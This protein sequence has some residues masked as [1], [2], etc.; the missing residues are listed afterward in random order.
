MKRTVALFLTVL[1]SFNLCACDV[2]EGRKQTA[3]ETAIYT[4]CF[5]TVVRI[6]Y[7]GDVEQAEKMHAYLLELH[8]LF[9]IYESER[10]D[11]LAA[12]NKNAGYLPVMVDDRVWELLQFGKQCYT[13][14]DGAINMMM[15]SVLTLWKQALNNGILPTQKELSPASTHTNI[16]SLILDAESKTAFI[17]DSQ[18]SIDVGAFAKGYAGK[19]A[20]A[21]AKE[22]LPDV[23]LLDLGGNICTV[24]EK[25]DGSTFQI[26]IRD[27]RS[28]GVLTTVSVRAGMCVVSGGDYQRYCVIDGVRYHHIIDPKTCAPAVAHCAVSVICEDSA[29]ADFLST[30]LFILSDRDGQELLLQY[31]NTRALLVT[32]DSAQNC[33]QKW[34]GTDTGLS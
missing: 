10:P 2:T 23:Y 25:P 22:E 16:D 1:L 17:S 11:G 3:M 20:M 27:P 13:V 15:G 6:C 14:S 18:A 28:D 31:P 4:D 19:L 32:E 5:D 9:D 26:G 33:I 34:I 29:V 12:L 30:A 7:I 21:Y 8:A 24:R